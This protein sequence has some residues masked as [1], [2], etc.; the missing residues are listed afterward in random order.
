VVREATEREPHDGEPAVPAPVAVFFWFATI[1]ATDPLTGRGEGR[2]VVVRHNQ[3]R[4]ALRSNEE[5]GDF[6]GRK[7]TI[8]YILPTC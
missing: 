1:R 8:F 2:L 6:E 5:R 4:E 7:V 3:E